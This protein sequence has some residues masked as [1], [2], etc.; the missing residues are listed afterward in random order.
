MR[1]ITEETPNPLPVVVTIGDLCRGY[2]E[3]KK[4]Y[5]GFGDY[6]DEN[7]IPMLVESLRNSLPGTVIYEINL[8][9]RVESKIAPLHTRRS[10]KFEYAFDIEARANFVLGQYLSDKEDFLSE[11]LKREV[12]SIL[13]SLYKGRLEFFGLLEDANNDLVK[14]LHRTANEVFLDLD[15]FEDIDLNNILLSREVPKEILGRIA[16]YRK[17]LIDYYSMGNRDS[18]KFR[19]LKDSIPELFHD[20]ENIKKGLNFI[21]AGSLLN[22]LLFPPEFVYE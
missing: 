7:V 9:Q 10:K 20:P 19:R 22:L 16:S 5:T 18:E 13:Q 6:V 8:L 4:Q 15:S 2:D 21:N 17:M 11:A 1:Q 12:Y 3:L 14:E